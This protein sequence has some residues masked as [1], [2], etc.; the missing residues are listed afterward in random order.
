MK[1]MPKVAKHLSNQGATFS[2]GFSSTPMCCPSRSSILTGLYVH[3]HAVYTNND[4]CSSSY[5]VK[6]RS[7]FKF[8]ITKV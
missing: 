5:W 8:R 7:C 1:F 6:V 3:N 2:Q 4:N